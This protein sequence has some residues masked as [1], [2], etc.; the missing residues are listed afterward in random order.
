MSS[1][2]L[3]TITELR[4]QYVHSFKQHTPVE[5]LQLKPYYT[6]PC[7]S[8]VKNLQAP[9]NSGIIAEFKRASPSKGNINENANVQAVI[10]QYQAFGAVATSILTEPIYF[11]GKNEDI[12]HV[13]E[14]TFIP[15]L[16]KDFIVDEYQIHEAKS[17]GAD[18]ILLIAAALTKE[19]VSNFAALA[20][21]LGLE[22]LLEV[23]TKEEIAFDNA[24]VDMVGVNNR[25]LK[26]FEVDINLSKEL[27]AF[28]PKHKP[29]IA[30]SGLSSRVEVDALRAVGFSG[31]LIGESL[32]KGNFINE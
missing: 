6:R 14:E 32:M 18:V 13:R 28:L 11:K 5:Q 15:I 17:L 23:H 31:F 26:T 29:A 7:I 27:F 9:L 25:N 21:Q 4:K 2:I 22:V 24:F 16:R 19:Q 30:E 10:K 8:L 12:L 1:T 20:K 3:H